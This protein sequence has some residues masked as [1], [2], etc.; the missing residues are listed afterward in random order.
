MYVGM[1]LNLRSGFYL[2]YISKTRRPR[3]EG[4]FSPEERGVTLGGDSVGSGGGALRPPCRARST[5][6]H[7]TRWRS[8]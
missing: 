1:N 3:G 4:K 2:R 7:S 5:P 8:G 6:R